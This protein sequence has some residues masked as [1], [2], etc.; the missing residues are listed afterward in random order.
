VD[1]II[2]T[3]YYW[4]SSTAKVEQRCDVIGSR[5][6]SKVVGIVAELSGRYRKRAISQQ[7]RDEKNVVEA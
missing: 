7:Q 5:V 4:A 1:H 6:N 3:R 2:I